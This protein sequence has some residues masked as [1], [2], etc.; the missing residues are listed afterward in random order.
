MKNSNK[1]SV[2]M[3]LYCRE[4]MQMKLYQPSFPVC[5]LDGSG[6]KSSTTNRGYWLCKFLF[7]QEKFNYEV[8]TQFPENS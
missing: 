1:T 2:S 4:K 5:P 3:H 6:K 7:V 8:K